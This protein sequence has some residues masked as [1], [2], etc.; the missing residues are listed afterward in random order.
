MLA[1]YESNLNDVAKK[2]LPSHYDAKAGST[3]DLIDML[4]KYPDAKE[5]MKGDKTWITGDVDIRDLTA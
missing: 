4:S 2:L 1:L 3:G 5:L